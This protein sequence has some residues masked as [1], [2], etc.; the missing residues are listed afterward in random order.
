M[1]LA[2]ARVSPPSHFG[3]FAAAYLALTVALGLTRG[4]IGTPISLLAAS[5]AR[6][7][8]ESNRAFRRLCYVS[9]PVTVA[10][11]VVLAAGPPATA[12][13]TL[14]LAFLP[15]ILLQDAG[16]FE[17]LALGRM[18]P[19]ILADAAWAAVSFG[20]LASTWAFGAWTTA[21]VLVLLWGLGSCASLGIL[22]ANRRHRGAD[23]ADEEVSTS[24]VT[25]GDRVR[26]GLDASMGGVVAL[27]VT[28]AVS[29][30]LSPVAVAA[31]RGAS[32]LLG[33]VN[34]LI[35]SLQVAV[36]PTM[37]RRP[38]ASLGQLLRLAAPVSIAI[39]SCAVGV[40]LIGLFLPSPI[41]ELAL[42]ET[43]NLAAPV[44]V[45]LSVEYV[46]QAILT[47]L[48]TVMRAR[49][50]SR[51]LIR[52]RIGMGTAQAALG[53]TAAGVFSTAV[54]VACASALVAWLMLPITWVV[55]SRVTTA[56]P[57]PS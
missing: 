27:G 34:V 13:S 25:T 46:G 1:V 43:W 24:R 56:G 45:V 29:V 22:V 6:V 17:S 30:I 3:I 2:I 26:L 47:A 52:L 9:L 23:A 12:S 15:V 28:G 38:D 37:V 11:L 4:S 44:L 5:A 21:P 51:T 16:R 54:A 40:G 31:L 41:G 49:N 48:W 55:A 8:A 20:M 7:R 32:T 39:A 57:R 36:V 10:G 19:A 33:P 35:S 14:M 53:V 42:G 50:E 18:T